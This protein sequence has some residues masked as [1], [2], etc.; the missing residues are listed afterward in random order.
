M[1]GPAARTVLALL[2]MHQCS[3]L[4]QNGP[5]ELLGAALECGH[6][7]RLPHLHPEADVDMKPLLRLDTST[8]RRLG[9]CAGPRGACAG[10]F[11]RL[12]ST[13]HLRGH[14]ASTTG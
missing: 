6:V 14:P 7:H 4:L 5:H 1:K 11:R 8:P 2:A 12:D 10:P 3:P 9:A 13:G